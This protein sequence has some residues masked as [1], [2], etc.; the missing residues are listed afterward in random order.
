MYS[1]NIV[2]NYARDFLNM[3]ARVHLCPVSIFERKWKEKKKDSENID[4]IF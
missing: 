4:D 2:L 3:F 1:R